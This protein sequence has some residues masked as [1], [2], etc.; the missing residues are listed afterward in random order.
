MRRESLKLA[1]L[2]R[3][4]AKMRVDFL[5]QNPWCIRC[6]G[7]ATEVHHKAGRGLNLLN[8]DTWAAACSACHSYITT[9]PQ[10]SYDRGWSL[11]R[12]GVS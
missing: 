5:I 6:G 8:V 12:I 2:R 1:R 3:L 7:E 11:R 4:Y 9:H 10:E